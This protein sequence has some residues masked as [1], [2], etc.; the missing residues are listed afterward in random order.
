MMENIT[1]ALIDKHLRELGVSPESN[2]DPTEEM[3]ARLQ[4]ILG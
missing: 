2:V 1:P 3:L 4:P